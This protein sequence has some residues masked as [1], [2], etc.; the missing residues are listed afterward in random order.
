MTNEVTLKTFHIQRFEGLFIAK[1]DAS[2]LKSKVRA[3]KFESLHFGNSLVISHV[4]RISQLVSR[5]SQSR[6]LWRR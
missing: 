1:K 3:E 2:A 5:N 6:D 4:Q